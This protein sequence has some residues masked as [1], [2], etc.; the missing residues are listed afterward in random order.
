MLKLNN[1]MKYITLLLFTLVYSVSNSMAQNYRVPYINRTYSYIQ[2]DSSKL[3]S[4]PENKRLGEFFSKYDD[5]C[6]SGN[7]KL[8]ILH[9]GGSH[10]QAGVWS[11]EMRRLLETICPGMEGAIGFVFPFS[12]AKTNH[13]YYYTSSYSGDWHVSKITDKEPS[14]NIGLAGIMAFTEDSIAEITIKFNKIADIKNHSFNKINLF[15]NIQDTCYKIKIYPDTL[16]D[17]FYTNEEIGVT[18]FYFREAI[19]SFKLTIEKKDSCKGEFH[20]YGAYLENSLPGI[21][22][23]GI[24][25]NGASTA[26]YLKA[27]LFSKHLKVIKPDLAIFSIGVNDAVS[28]DFSGDVYMRNYRIIVDKVLESNPECAIIFTTN[29]D[30]YSYSGKVNLNHDKLY[31]SLCNLSK[32]YGASVWDMYKIMGGYKSINLWKKDENAKSDRIHFTVNGYKIIAELFF[33]A[34]L[35]D[36]EK[37]LIEL[38]KTCEK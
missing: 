25:I 8:S 17:S 11:W 18:E 16:I 30:F 38:S 33:E 27:S 24:G 34:I 22:Y 21:N 35:K 1:H 2:Y 23:T 19:D 26:S 15:Y 29:N 9:V 6:F 12:I 31:N 7:S 5:L 4:F 37:H 13:P 36:Y 14:R 10:I 32:V 20:F 28:P 3:E